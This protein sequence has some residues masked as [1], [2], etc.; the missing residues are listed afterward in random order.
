MSERLKAVL[1]HSAVVAR[2]GGDEFAVLLD[3]MPGDGARR[4]AEAVKEALRAP[5]AIDG[6]QVTLSASMG[7]LVIETGAQDARYT[8]GLRESD[9]AMYAA[10]SAGGNRVIEAGAGSATG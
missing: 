9:R 6:Q 8:E 1:P 7:R 2:L 5:Y 10:K 4:A 3:N